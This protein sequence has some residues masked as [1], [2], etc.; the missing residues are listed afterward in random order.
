MDLTSQILELI[1]ISSTDLPADVEKAIQEATKREEKGSSAETVLLTI[2][3]NIKLARKETTAMCQDTGALVFYIDYPEGGIERIYRDGILEAVKEATKL[4]YLRPNTVEPLSGKNSGNNIGINAPYLHFH[5]WEKDY[6]RIRFMQKGGGCENC[7]AQY[8]LPDS[9]L[10]AGRDIKGVRKAIIDAVFQAQ[11]QGCA[12]AILGISIGG[13]RAVSYTYAKEQL[14]RKI[15]ERNQDKEIA[16]FEVE[17]CKELNS[18]GIGPM[19]FGGKTTILDVLVGVQHRHPASFFVS[20][21]YMCW[22]SRR[23]TL[24]IKGSEVEYD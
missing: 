24:T 17:L 3:E 5:Q 18:M 6:V 16:E 22:A 4:S 14:F 19:G 7:G 9:T 23:R 20:I 15:G 8:R 21:S 11:G 10:N 1:R 2:E 12:P 13:D